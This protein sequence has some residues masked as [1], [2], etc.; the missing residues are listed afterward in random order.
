MSFTRI[1]GE[2]SIG[3]INRALN[4]SLSRCREDDAQVLAGAIRIIACI[5]DSVV[6]KAILAH[7]VGKA[8][9]AQSRLRPGRAPPA[10]AVS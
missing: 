8:C 5:E 9:S 4:P 2:Q 1:F 6:I 3:G 10:P 7:P